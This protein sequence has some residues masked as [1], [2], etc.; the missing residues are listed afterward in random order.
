MSLVK[1]HQPLHDPA[2]LTG[3]QIK[4]ALGLLEWGYRDLAERTGMS[5][6]TIQNLANYQDEESGGMARSWR[7]IQNELE[8]AGIE[9][10]REGQS[11]EPGGLGVR[12]KGRKADE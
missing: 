7:L 3:K 11:V 6:N 8:K 10:I 4:A 5:K 1:C 12:L 2:M 9:F